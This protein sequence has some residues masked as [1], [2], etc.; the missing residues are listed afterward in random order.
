MPDEPLTR[1][2]IE[3]RRDA[4]IRRA[5]NTPPKPTK[6]LIGK[7]EG[8]RDQRKIKKARPAKPKSP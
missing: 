4:A 7:T 1:E 5:L 3:R 2:E 6:E 8:A